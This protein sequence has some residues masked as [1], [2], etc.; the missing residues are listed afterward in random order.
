MQIPSYMEEVHMYQAKAKSANRTPAALVATPD[1]VEV[2]IFLFF[3]ERGQS[4]KRKPGTEKEEFR[5]SQTVPNWYQWLRGLAEAHIAW[6]DRAPVPNV[7]IDEGRSIL[8]GELKSMKEDPIT[9]RIRGNQCGT[10]RDFFR[11]AFPRGSTLG[12][13][14]SGVKGKQKATL[15]KQL[16]IVLPVRVEE[17]EVPDEYS[18]IQRRIK[19]EQPEPSSSKVREIHFFKSA[20]EISK[21]FP[22]STPKPQKQ[23]SQKQ[24]LPRRKPPGASMLSSLRRKT[25]CQLGPIKAKAENGLLI[26]RSAAT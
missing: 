7:V 23:K 6:M 17:E 3:Y 2:A 10:I 21:S 1:T 22:F 25:Q 14:A 16:A 20:V 13:G 5:L 11:Y 19:A 9:S 18:G 26:R 24:K 8:V 12:Q 4:P 15:M